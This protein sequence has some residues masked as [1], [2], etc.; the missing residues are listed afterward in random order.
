MEGKTMNARNL[1]DEATLDDREFAEQYDGW[2]DEVY[3][4]VQLG[5]L[6]YPAGLVLKEVDPVAYECGFTD[7][8]DSIPDPWE[9]GECGARYEDEEDAE[10]CCKDDID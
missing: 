2:L 8:L 1:I 10:E 3:G 6:T 7:W 4:D 9:C 5:S